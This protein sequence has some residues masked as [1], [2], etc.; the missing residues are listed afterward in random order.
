MTTGGVCDWSLRYWEDGAL[1]AILLMM[2]GFLLMA[3]GTLNVG[4]IDENLVCM[5][6]L[7]QAEPSMRLGSPGRILHVLFYPRV[8]GCSFTVAI[9]EDVGHEVHFN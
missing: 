4:G 5:Y 6:A 3:V 9:A 8:I 1:R 2:S 7:V